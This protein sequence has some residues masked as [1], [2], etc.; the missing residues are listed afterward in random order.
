MFLNKKAQST[1]EYG[2]VIAIVVA[3][4]LAIN[5]YMKRGVQGRLRSSADDIGEQF[6]ARN[7][8]SSYTT[9]RGG[10]TVEL[11]AAG[12]TTTYAGAGGKGTAECVT[13]TGNESIDKW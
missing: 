13:R 8:S 2:L 9:T 10:K 4:L 3:A 11:T 6:E 5:I 1:L 12:E 7:T